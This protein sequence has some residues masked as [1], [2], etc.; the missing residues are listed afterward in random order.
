MNLV[1]QWFPQHTQKKPDDLLIDNMCFVMKFYGI[2]K[3]ELDELDIPEFI[4]MRDYAFEYT[5]KETER[6]NKMFGGG[7]SGGGKIRLGGRR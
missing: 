4:I 5:K 6:F 7:K 3:R 1:E 2:S